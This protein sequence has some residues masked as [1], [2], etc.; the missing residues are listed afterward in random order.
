MKTLLPVRLRNN[1]WGERYFL[2]KSKWLRR[3][4]KFER[5]WKK[6]FCYRFI[7]LELELIEFY[8]CI[9]LSSLLSRVTTK[10]FYSLNKSN[11]LN[12]TYVEQNKVVQVWK[13]PTKRSMIV[14]LLCWAMS[15]LI[16]S[17]LNAFSSFLKFEIKNKHNQKQHINIDWFKTVACAAIK[18]LLLLQTL[19]LMPFLSASK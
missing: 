5:F 6:I 13:R 14:P 19:K 16:I 2:N 11:L 4:V 8:C 17:F 12:L 9:L 1:I 7:C 10:V 3:K 18:L 15:I